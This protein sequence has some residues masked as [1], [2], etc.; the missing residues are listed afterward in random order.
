[1]DI[2][3]KPQGGVA[4]E[5]PEHMKA[6]AWINTYDDLDALINACSTDDELWEL[7]QRMLED[8]QE[9]GHEGVDVGEVYEE[10]LGWIWT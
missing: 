6:R 3:H 4:N 1:M 10:L 2:H 9:S 5:D 7:A 8:A